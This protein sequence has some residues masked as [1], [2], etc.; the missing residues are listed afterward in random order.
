M[1][2]PNGMDKFGK[3]MTVRGG[4]ADILEDINDG[5]MVLCLSGGLHQVQAPGQ[6][7]PRLFKR[8][9]MNLA[10]FNIVEYKKKFADLSPRERKLRITQDLQKHLE[11]SC[12]K[13]LI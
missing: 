3:P 2:R 1:K 8:I 6:Q 13:P 4:V 5:A 11:E 10:Y 9:E 12:P 7:L